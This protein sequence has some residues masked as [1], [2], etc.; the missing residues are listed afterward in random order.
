MDSLYPFPVNLGEYSLQHSLVDTYQFDGFNLNIGMLWRTPDNRLSVGIVFKS[1]FTGDIKHKTVEETSFDGFFEN[2]SRKYNE[3]L[4]MP[5]SYG[6]GILYKFTDSLKMAVDIYHTKW[7]DFIYKESNGNRISPITGEPANKSHI[8]ST[9]QVHIGMEYLFKNSK[10]Y[11]V[12][13]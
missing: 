9:T 4:D 2:K 3:K 6:L 11:H 5:A 13:Q 7:E 1:P 8:K 12:I 10:L